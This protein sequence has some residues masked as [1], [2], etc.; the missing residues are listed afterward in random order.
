MSYISILTVMEIVFAKLF[1]SA[2]YRIEFSSSQLLILPLS[3]AFAI[4]PK[5]IIPK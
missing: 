5:Y 1:K 3:M 4:F 2:L